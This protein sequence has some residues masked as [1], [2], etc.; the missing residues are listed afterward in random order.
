MPHLL[1]L[2]KDEGMR[3]ALADLSR[4]SGYSVARAACVRD[5]LLQI[6]MRPPDLFVVDADRPESDVVNVCRDAIAVGSQVVIMMDNAGLEQTMRSLNLGISHY[7]NKPVCLKQLQAMMD[8][9]VSMGLDQATPDTVNATC[10]FT[11]MYGESESMHTVYRQISRV[12]PT[13]MSV[14]VIGESGTG[15]ELVAQAIHDSSAR[16]RQR[17]LAVNCGAIAPNLIE[18]EMFGHER[19]SFTGADKQCKGYFE[20]ADGGTLFLDEI[21]EMSPDLQVKLLRVLETGRF[22]RVGAHKE[23]ACNVRVVAATNRCPEQAVHDGKLR[24]DL[25]YRLAAFPLELPA[26]RERGDDVLLLAN[27]FLA[28]FNADSGRQNYFSEE[29][30]KTLRTHDWPGNVRELRNVVRRTCIMADTEEL[31]VMV[32]PS[33]VLASD[34]PSNKITLRVGATLAE[35]NRRLIIA[36]L[37][38]CGGVREQTADILGMSTKTLYHR[39]ETY[40]AAGYR[41]PV[42]PETSRIEN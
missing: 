16:R 1:I 31:D 5:A 18:S 42:T 39:L 41:V 7:L 3:D 34:E 21:T 28:Q 17:F 19:G 40:A 8:R 12:A 32:M 4:A 24:S 33:N 9:A 11:G 25:Y 14:L 26:L 27:L 37:M 10:H 30:L 35:A 23:V 15:K 29:A 6:D 22:M 2:D 20:R 13:D 38:R 36:T